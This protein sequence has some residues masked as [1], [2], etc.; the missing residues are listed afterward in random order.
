V[1]VLQ[2][3]MDT[4]T[5]VMNSLVVKAQT[6]MTGL[7]LSMSKKTARN[8]ENFEEYRPFFKTQNVLRDGGGVVNDQV[9]MYQSLGRSCIVRRYQD[10]KCVFFYQIPKISCSFKYL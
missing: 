8:P 6:T 3:G 10:G 7:P 2:R 5:L 1:R 9:H 4:A